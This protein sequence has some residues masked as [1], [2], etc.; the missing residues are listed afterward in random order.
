[1][2]RATPFLLVLFLALGLTFPHLQCILGGTWQNNLG[3]NMT[4][5]TMD[6]NGDFFGTYNTSVSAS[7]QKVLPSLMLGSQRL[8]IKEKDIT[9]GFTV[10]W[11]F[12]DSI[13]VFTGQ[14]FVDEEGK[15]VLKTMWLLRSRV[16]GIKNDWKATT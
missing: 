7:Q 3:S 12:S 10:H 14:C 11:T 4:I 1:M 2:V 13:S 5:T 6:E 8:P 16:E 15:E 9:F